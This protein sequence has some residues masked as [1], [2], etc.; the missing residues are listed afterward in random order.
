MAKNK[1]IFLT[2]A[3]APLDQR[4]ML[5]ATLA[6]IQLPPMSVEDFLAQVVAVEADAEKAKAA[7][8]DKAAKAERNKAIEAL[9]VEAEEL[10]VTLDPE[11]MD[12]IQS[13]LDRMSELKGDQ[14]APV[15]MAITGIVGTSL[16]FEVTGLK[17]RKGS[18]GGGKPAANQPRDYVDVDGNRVV[19]SLN[20]WATDNLDAY[21]FQELDDDLDSLLLRNDKGE[22]KGGTKLRN[23]LVKKGYIVASPV[24]SEEMA[25]WEAGKAS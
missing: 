12:V 5:V 2:V 13:I 16:T 25:E 17:V 21:D 6:P 11:D 7:A 3:A 23:R 14:K 19:G 4:D 18:T 1:Q 15:V 9:N 10:S 24:T 8:V 22:L 20:K